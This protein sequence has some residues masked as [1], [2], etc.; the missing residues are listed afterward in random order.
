VIATGV[1]IREVRA[2]TIDK[3]PIPAGTKVD[4]AR[5][6]KT[7]AGLGFR[8]FNTTRWIEEDD[9]KCMFEPEQVIDYTKHLENFE[10]SI[11]TKLFG[12]EFKNKE[13]K[14]EAAHGTTKHITKPSTTRPYKKKKNRTNYMDKQDLKTAIS[15]L[16]IG[17]E[18]T[19][20]F[21]SVY[22]PECVSNSSRYGDVLPLVGQSKTYTL[23]ETKKGRGKGGSKLMVLASAD[24]TKISIGT[25]HS[26]TMLNVRTPLGL[27]GHESEA[28]VEKIYETNAGQAAN[29]TSLFKDL[30]VLS[31]PIT[32][33]V[34]S[35]EPTFNGDFTVRET[36]QLRGRYGQIRLTLQ[37]VD[38]TTVQLWS[39]RHS[40][41]VTNFEV[42]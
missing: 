15:G 12:N 7:P 36:E 21:L 33:R 8:I 26:E 11:F 23:V 39:Y 22:P 42:L 10:D 1:I 38:G 6:T 24:G 20:T 35:T 16:Q 32:V 19:L 34:A 41:V 17:N 30:V 31:E 37:R 3:F 29:L 25:P 13:L 9:I 40:G 2:N 4:I 18:V 5:I 27:F 28:D 14:H